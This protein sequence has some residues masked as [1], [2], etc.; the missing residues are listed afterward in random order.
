MQAQSQEWKMCYVQK[1]RFKIEVALN[2][3]M[4]SLVEFNRETGKNAEH[5][6]SNSNGNQHAQGVFPETYS[7]K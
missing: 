3:E 6:W 5:S 4:S 2:D 1:K 7:V